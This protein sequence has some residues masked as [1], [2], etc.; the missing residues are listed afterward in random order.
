MTVEHT[1]GPALP[2][3]QMHL[4]PPNAPGIGTV[5]ETRRC[6]SNKKAAGVVRHISIDV[7]K[8]KLAGN[9]FSGQSFGV[10]PPGLDA[11]GQ[12]HK[13]RLYSI[14][15]PTTGEDGKGQVL[16]TTVKRLVDE[17]H[18][19][20]KLFLG[21]ASNYLC[22]L[23]VGDTVEVTGPVGKRFLLP[24]DPSAHDYVFFATGTGIAPFR[25]MLLDLL[26]TNCSSRVILVMGS[27]YASDLLYHQE[28]EALAK[29]HANFQ[30]IT[31]ISREKQDDGSRPLYVHDRLL[32]HASEFKTLLETDRGLIYICGI[33]GM[34]LG[35]M[36]KLAGILSPEALDQYIGLD[37]NIRDTVATWDRKMIHKQVRPT[38][39]MF[40][41][42]Y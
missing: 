9:F 34:E 10:L 22:D 28:L 37:D 7:S 15:S 4:H 29:K 33:A 14:A 1:P 8:T 25:G 21:V 41:E 16:A 11:K 26:S 31:A 32:T 27:P 24:A 40:M 6:T 39:K 23:Q 19:T 20:H 17:H 18:D 36:Q 3:V 12:A 5:V 13:L 38:R 35:V 2:Q 30:Y 42:V